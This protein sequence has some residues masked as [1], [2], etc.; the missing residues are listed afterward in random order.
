MNFQ[1]YTDNELVALREL[2]IESLR[3]I[4][5][6]AAICRHREDMHDHLDAITDVTEELIQRNVIPNFSSSYPDE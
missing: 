2:W 6:T 3:H 5:I 1:E 4:T